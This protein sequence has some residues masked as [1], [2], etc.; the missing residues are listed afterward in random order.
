[1]FICWQAAFVQD[2]DDDVIWLWIE[3]GVEH[4]F[5]AGEVKCP[6][7]LFLCN[8]QVFQKFVKR[9]SLFAARLSLIFQ[10]LVERTGDGVQKN[11]GS[12]LAVVGICNALQTLAFYD[13]VGKILKGRL[14]QRIH[15]SYCFVQIYKP[16]GVDVLFVHGHLDLH[17]VVIQDQRGC[18]YAGH[19]GIVYG[20][21]HGGHGFL[22]LFFGQKHNDEQDNKKNTESSEN[23]GIY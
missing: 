23:A 8:L 13:L 20:L 21:R 5:A 4:D 18:I 19:V 14:D 15:G 1:M 22:L 7:R 2:Y 17:Y 10:R 6:G 16:D 11:H 9:I 3:L 12:V